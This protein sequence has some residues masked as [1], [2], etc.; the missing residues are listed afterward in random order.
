MVGIRYKVVVGVGVR[1]RVDD[2]SR[3]SVGVRSRVLVGVVVRT[4]VGD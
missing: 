1:T 3:V 2:W 4:W